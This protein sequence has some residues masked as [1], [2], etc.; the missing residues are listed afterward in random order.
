MSIHQ[1]AA[2]GGLA[3]ALI[4]LLLGTLADAKRT[5]ESINDGSDCFHGERFT[6]EGAQDHG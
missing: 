4:A 2:L 1:I 6:I 3:G 5:N